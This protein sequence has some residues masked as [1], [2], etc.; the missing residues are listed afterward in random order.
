MS[1]LEHA[2]A[3]LLLSTV[4]T[5]ACNDRHASSGEAPAPSTPP[6]PEP[7]K[8]PPQQPAPAP[9][10][11]A[12]PAAEPAPATPEAPAAEERPARQHKPAPN[13]AGERRSAAPAAAPSPEREEPSAKGAAA[14][15]CGEKGQPACPLQGWMER[16]LQQPLDDGDFAK[17]AQGLARVPKF[18]PD[19][20]WNAGAQGWS[21]IAEAGESAAKQ[22]DAAAAR[23]SCKTCHKTWRS[24]YK[25][26]FRLRPIA[27]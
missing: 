24:K 5:Q 2:A 26:S 18:V 17:V 23:Q 10:A 14:A 8:E 27:D 1:R 21:A 11:P 19:P 25:A 3:V 6:A 12:A 20:S 16:H 13:A 4:F 22:G 7:T 9:A 15:P